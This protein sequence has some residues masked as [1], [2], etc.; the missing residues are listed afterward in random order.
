MTSWSSSTCLGIFWSFKEG[1][2]LVLN[3]LI[4]THDTQGIE[5]CV[6]YVVPLCD[7]LD[8]KYH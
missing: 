4:S 3:K 8:S 6:Y 5:N 7:K 1:A 2:G